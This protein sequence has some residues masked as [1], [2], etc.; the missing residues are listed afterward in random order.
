MVNNLFFWIV[1]HCVSNAYSEVVCFVHQHTGIAAT[2][3]QC[4]E[5]GGICSICQA[6]YREPRVLL[7]QV[8]THHRA[9][10]ARIFL[11]FYYCWSYVVPAVPGH[12]KTVQSFTHWMGDEH[13]LHVSFLLECRTCWLAVASLLC[14]TYSVTS[15]SP[16]GSIERRA[17][18][19][20][21]Q[22]SQRRSTNGGMELHRHTCRF[23]DGGELLYYWYCTGVTDIILYPLLNGSRQW[24]FGYFTCTYSKRVSGLFTR[25]SLLVTVN[26]ELIPVLE[27]LCPW[28]LHFC[29]MLLLFNLIML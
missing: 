14:S 6:E 19:C 3:S 21:V 29:L 1:A 18:L 2:R 12:H 27:V 20:A 11:Y 9:R 8:T 28:S 26:W 4:N 25:S 17:A 22:W 15:A 24:P 16:C 7:C 13:S 23:T 10:H 5:A